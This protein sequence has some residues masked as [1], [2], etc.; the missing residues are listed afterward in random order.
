ML[1]QHGGKFPGFSFWFIFPRHR[2]QETGNPEMPPSPNESLPFL[3]KGP[4]KEQISKTEH[5]QEVTILLTLNNTNNLPHDH[6]YQQRTHK[7]LE[8]QSH[9]AMMRCPNTL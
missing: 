3:P 7:E 1:D 8:F 6:F 5:F 2:A 9:E 4:R